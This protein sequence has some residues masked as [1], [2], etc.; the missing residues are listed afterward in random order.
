MALHATSRTLL[1]LLAGCILTGSLSEYAAVGSG[2]DFNRVP[3]P[4]TPLT[5]A[6]PLNF[7]GASDGRSWTNDRHPPMKTDQFGRF[8]YLPSKDTQ[9]YVSFFSI[10]GRSC[11]YLYAESVAHLPRTGGNIRLSADT[12]VTFSVVQVKERGG[13]VVGKGL[14]GG[15][16][17][18]YICT[19]DGQ[20][21]R[22]SSGAGR[23]TYDVWKRAETG[24]PTYVDTGVVAAPH[25]IA[26]PGGSG[27]LDVPSEIDP[28]A[29][30]SDWRS[31]DHHLTCSDYRKDGRERN[32]CLDMGY[33]DPTTVDP[34]AKTGNIHWDVPAYIG[35]PTACRVCTSC[36]LN[37]TLPSTAELVKKYREEGVEIDGCKVGYDCKNLINAPLMELGEL[38]LTELD[39]K[40]RE[41]PLFKPNYVPLPEFNP[42]LTKYFQE[43]KYTCKFTPANGTS[44]GEERLLVDLESG[45]TFEERFLFRVFSATPHALVRY[46]LDG[47]D[48]SYDHGTLVM[49]GGKRVFFKLGVSVLRVAGIAREPSSCV[50]FALWH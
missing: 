38:I 4:V 2:D 15:R 26:V 37:A 44:H 1:F 34:R 41:D 11:G 39:L 12:T 6:D 35:C 3:I 22:M 14:V 31:M 20:Y 33:I 18:A 21:H 43:L 9:P 48:P 5:S 17:Y 29:D 25:F 30:R 40:I 36:T 19:T 7:A 32:W 27:P 47:S 45:T 42:T 13:P 49:S 8:L 46:T 10:S 50:A 16:L 24:L 23:W 28:C